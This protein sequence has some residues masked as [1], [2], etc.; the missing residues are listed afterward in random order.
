MYNL[1]LEHFLKHLQWVWHISKSHQLYLLLKHLSV[2]ISSHLSS[3][4]SL[5]DH[6]ALSTASSDTSSF[7]LG[8]KKQFYWVES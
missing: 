2:S 7:S 1:K 4:W 3:W 6:G 5:C 8:A